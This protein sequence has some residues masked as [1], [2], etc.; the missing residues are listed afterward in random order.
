MARRQSRP[1]DDPDSRALR[2]QPGTGLAALASGHVTAFTTAD[3]L[4]SN[5]IRSLHEDSE[6]VLWIGSYDGG[7]TRFKDGEFTALTVKEGLSSNGV[8]CILEDQRGW[9]WMNSNQGLR[10]RKQQLT[11]CRW[12]EP[13]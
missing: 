7:L 12:Q 5:H 6:R 13:P 3:G 2:Y 8:F 9:F 10:V 1:R 11:D 4:A